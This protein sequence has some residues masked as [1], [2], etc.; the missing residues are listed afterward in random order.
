MY[1]DADLH[2]VKEAERIL[3]RAKWAFY[4]ELATEKL[5]GTL[6]LQWTRLFPQ[7]PVIQIV[8]VDGEVVGRIRQQG[9]RWL[10][11][12]R[13]GRGPVADCETFGAALIA[14]ACEANR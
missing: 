7:S 4:E 13:P 1:D 14:L 6:S 3:Y 5:S 11:S 8:A 12:G 10:A 2:V 9:D